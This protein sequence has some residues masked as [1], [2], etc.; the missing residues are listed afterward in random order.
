MARGGGVAD[1]LLALA[2]L[3]N[4]RPKTTALLQLGLV[5]GYTLG[6]S[7]IA[8]GLWLDPFGGLLKNLPVLALILVHLALVEER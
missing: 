1:A 3:R 4:W 6:L 2:L 7:L 8:P 5:G